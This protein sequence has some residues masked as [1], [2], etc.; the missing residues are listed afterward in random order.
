M[1][2][3]KAMASSIF[4]TPTEGSSTPLHS[5]KERLTIAFRLL[6]PLRIIRFALSIPSLSTTRRSFWFSTSSA[7]PGVSLVKC[8]FLV[9]PLALRALF[10]VCVTNHGTARLSHSYAIGRSVSIMSYSEK[11]SEL[12]MSAL[13]YS[14]VLDICRVSQQF[15]SNSPKLP[16]RLPM[17]SKN[18]F[19]PSAFLAERGKSMSSS[20]PYPRSR[21]ARNESWKSSRRASARRTYFMLLVE[22]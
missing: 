22:R 17:P 19:A 6:L 4:H 16:Y 12:L 2:H 20:S 18:S 1:L 7:S 15:T 13:S 8:P 5:H 3:T 11:G 14:I 21:R 9:P 10:I